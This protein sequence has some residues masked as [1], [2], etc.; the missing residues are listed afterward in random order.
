MKQLS[1][2]LLFVAAFFFQATAQ[3]ANATTPDP[4][5]ETAARKATELLVTKYHLNAD[6]AKQMYQIQFRKQRNSA[7]IMP[8]KAENPT[9]YR[10]KVQSLQKGT[11]ASIRRIMQNKEQ[12][13]LYQQTQIAVRSLKAD[14]QKEMLALKAS[15]EAIETALLDI[16]SE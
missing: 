2:L 12:T 14:K 7:E 16:Y 8:I 15:K 10:A 6:Q 3:E 4:A 1:A 11:L 5:A 13:D 9:L